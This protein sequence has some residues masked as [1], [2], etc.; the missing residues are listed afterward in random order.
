MGEIIPCSWSM[1]EATLIGGNP[2][3]PLDIQWRSCED[4][5]LP[6]VIH[7]VKDQGCEFNPQV[8]NMS[9]CHVLQKLIGK[10]E[11]VESGC[12]LKMVSPF[13]HKF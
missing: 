7:T 6:T 12:L 8:L 3:I 2:Y 11:T 10:G 1:M 9:P 5:L 4:N 13:P